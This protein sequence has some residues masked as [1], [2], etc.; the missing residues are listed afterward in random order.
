MLHS[1][2]YF[3]T[4]VVFFT[5]YLLL[6]RNI[7]NPKVEE[8]AS[9]NISGFDLSASKIFYYNKQVNVVHYVYLRQVTTEI[10][11]I[12]M[13]LMTGKVIQIINILE[14]ITIIYNI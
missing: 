10:K 14:N 4:A 11:F 2:I 5:I 6:F 3:P 8:V 12:Y 13:F 1:L 9:L 7:P